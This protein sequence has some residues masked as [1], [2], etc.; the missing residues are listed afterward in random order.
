LILN[1]SSRYVIPTG[2]NLLYSSRYPRKLNLQP[3]QKARSFKLTAKYSA[4]LVYATALSVPPHIHL[5]H[6]I[7]PR[8]LSVR[9]AVVL[10]STSWVRHY[11]MSPTGPL[12]PPSTPTCTLTN[13][14]PSNTKAPPH[15]HLRA[16]RHREIHHSQTA[17]ERPP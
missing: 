13:K 5:Q 1:F 12:K 9:P 16:L 10:S 11:P 2:V 6:M 4:I 17:H 14:Q 8:L 7:S 3:R 15:S